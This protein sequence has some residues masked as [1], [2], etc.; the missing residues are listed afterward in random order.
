MEI[1]VLMGK[2]DK[3]SKI[4]PWDDSD[5][6]DKLEALGYDQAWTGN[7]C[8]EYPYNQINTGTGVGKGGVPTTDLAYS[9]PGWRGYM[10]NQYPQRETEIDKIEAM[11]MY[12]WGC[13]DCG[14]FSGHN[15]EG[16]PYVDKGGY[17]ANGNGTGATS[18]PG[19]WMHPNAVPGS[20]GNSGTSLGL[21]TVV[22]AGTANG[23]PMAGTEKDTFVREGVGEGHQLSYWDT[24]LPGGMLVKRDS[25]LSLAWI[26]GT[27]LP[28]HPPED[29]YK[30]GWGWAVEVDSEDGVYTFDGENLAMLPTDGP[31]R[32]RRSV[33]AGKSLLVDTDP[34]GSAIWVAVTGQSRSRHPRIKVDKFDNV[35]I[36][37]DG[38]GLGGSQTP[39]IEGYA[40]SGSTIFRYIPHHLGSPGAGFQSDDHP[41]LGMCIALDPNIPNYPNAFT[42]AGHDKQ[43]E[44]LY[45][46]LSNTA[47]IDTHTHLRKVAL[48]T[49]AP[50]PTGSQRV[51]R[52]VA[53]S[54]GKIMSWL[55]SEEAE[56]PADTAHEVGYADDLQSTPLLD[57]DAQ[58]V[59]G[60]VL[61][62]DVFFTDGENYA[63]YHAD[64][65]L[66]ADPA[67]V[68]V[69]K[70][71][72]TGSGELPKRCK[73][74]TTWRSRVVLARSAD[75]PHMWY[76][77]KAG[78]AYNWDFGP[79]PTTAIQAVAGNNV[80]RA[81]RSPDIVNAL[82]PYSD[83]L[84]IFGGDHAIWRLSGD[85][86]AGGEFDLV[87]D[88]TGI[89]FG[90]GWAKDPEGMLY[91]AGSRGGIF[92]MHPGGEFIRISLNAIERRLQ[93][94]NL[95]DYHFQLQWNYRE[96]GL[97]VFLVPFQGTAAAKKSSYFFER[98]TGAWYEDTWDSTD[99]QPTATCVFDG[100]NVNDRRVVLA[101]DDGY[102]REFSED[103]T[104]DDYMPSTQNS[105]HGVKSKVVIGPVPSGWQRTEFETRLRTLKCV[106][107]T[108]QG[109]VRWTT[110]ASHEPD[111]VGHGVATGSW[112]SGTNQI[113]HTRARGAYVWV[114]LYNGAKDGRWALESLG[115]DISRG[116]RTRV[117]D[118]QGGS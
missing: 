42:A 29:Q 4:T 113:V 1:I 59:Q 81:G 100:D 7:H 55:P 60:T 64:P 22:T 85:P 115:C 3:E 82:I 98:K 110:F 118:L 49:A 27:G 10:G 14:A 73:L 47:P 32:L 102:I 48:V 65:D 21:P 91:F 63:V 80:D 50:S 72:S 79:V 5:S 106:L 108:Q 24:F 104:G 31:G 105:N 40:Q 6:D 88:V 111:E 2:R 33:D 58:F 70:W 34:D 37:L 66:E 9:F 19:W 93:D 38:A 23:P 117:R 74:I 94:H 41:E 35:Y 99:L 57:T 86:M 53:E 25:D 20:G 90:S 68:E 103:A 52:F 62:N 87:S 114:Q 46:G 13:Q 78:D 109:G 44:F 15:N 69:Q 84:L 77:S 12:R 67:E 45:L 43:P 36:P 11:V 101:C 61:Y 97:H 18:A 8:V 54:N 92:A 75:D 28:G 107:G 112:V 71:A 51:I 95:E 16:Y 17:G 26:A 30:Y 83:D 116:G 76:M 96:E 56:S 89:A 39:L